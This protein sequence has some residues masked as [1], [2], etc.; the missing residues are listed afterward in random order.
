MMRAKPNSPGTIS[1]TY[2]QARETSIFLGQRIEQ[3]KRDHGMF[4]KHEAGK[5]LTPREKQ[6][7]LAAIQASIHWL[8]ADCRAWA[9]NRGVESK[10]VKALN[11]ITVKTKRLRQKGRGRNAR[12]FWVIET[13]AELERWLEENNLLLSVSFVEKDFLEEAKSLM[14]N[15][16]VKE[17]M[18]HRHRGVRGDRPLPPPPPDD[19]PPPP[20]DEPKPVSPDDLDD[21]DPDEEDADGHSF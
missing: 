21:P 14:I 13:T 12:D 10:L 20:D 16:A 11:E 4:L 3:I 8:R 7:R 6:E 5:M 2:D 19:L 15:E 1:D 17:A 18:R 9:R